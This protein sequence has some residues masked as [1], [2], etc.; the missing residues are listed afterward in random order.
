M[1][2]IIKIKENRDFRRIY[3]RGKSYVAPCVVVYVMK[4]RKNSVRFGI[5]AGKKVGGAVQRNRAKRVI[6]A[7]IRS[8]IENVQ[9]GYDV[10]VVARNRILNEKS[11]S[12]AEVLKRQFKAAGIWCESQNEQAVN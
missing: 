6:T 7:A 8:C 11:T 2:S 12:V 3:G 4:G 9:S 1:R 10:I 5:T